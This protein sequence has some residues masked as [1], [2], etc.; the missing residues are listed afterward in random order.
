M[1]DRPALSG[2]NLEIVPRILRTFHAPS[3]SEADLSLAIACNYDSQSF[4]RSCSQGVDVCGK[5]LFMTDKA[6]R[7][8][9][10]HLQEA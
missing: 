5:A 6:D 8:E 1:L 4:V 7:G 9:K 2:M 10:H 3:G